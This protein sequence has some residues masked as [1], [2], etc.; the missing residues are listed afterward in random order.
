MVDLRKKID[1]SKQDSEPI[2]FTQT[3]LTE[4]SDEDDIFGSMPF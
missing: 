1:E 4:I 3:Q 2:L